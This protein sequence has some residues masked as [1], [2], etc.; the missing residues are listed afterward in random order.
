[1][2][3]TK[4]L[5]AKHIQF[6]DEYM[7][8]GRNATQAY[9]KVYKCKETTARNQ[10]ALLLAKPCIRDEVN[11]RI[12]EYT[13]TAGIDAAWCVERLKPIADAP[14]GDEKVSTGDKIKAATVLLDY[15]RELP[16]RDDKQTST[17]FVQ[18]NVDKAIVDLRAAIE[19]R[20][21]QIQ[22]QPP[23]E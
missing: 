23:V 5:N 19:A 6:V 8:N 12:A 9:L 11:L 3:A 15:F 2:N 20:R 14:L 13:R 18:I 7:R 22:A 1:M 4:L 21:A 16:V 17:Q 10:A